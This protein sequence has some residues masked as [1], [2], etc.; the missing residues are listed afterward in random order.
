MM[1]TIGCC[2][3][4]NSLAVVPQTTLGLSVGCVVKAPREMPTDSPQLMSAVSVLLAV[5]FALTFAAAEVYMLPVDAV[6]A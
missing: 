3:D 1:P 4:A 5:D 2:D 6:V